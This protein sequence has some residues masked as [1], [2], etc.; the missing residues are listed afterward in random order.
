MQHARRARILRLMRIAIA[1][2]WF[3]PRQGG[4]ESQL[5]TLAERLAG[6]GHQVT[7]LTST[8]GATNGTNYAL[9]RIDGPHLPFADVAISPMLGATLRAAI[10]GQFDVVHAH[11]SVVSPVGYLAAFAAASQ[12]I[13]TVVTFH[14]V[15]RFK[16]VLLS[17]ANAVAQLGKLPIIWT[18]VSQLVAQQVRAGLGATDVDVL[19]NGIDLD[20]WREPDRADGG[21]HPVTF[22]SAMRLHRKKRP[23]ELVAAFARAADRAGKPARLVIAGVGPELAAVQRDIAASRSATV[24]VVGWQDKANLKA[25]YRQSDAFVLPSLREA[26]GIAALEARAAGLP[27]IASR[28]AGCREFLQHDHNA[29]LCDTDAEFAAAIERFVREPDLR[30]RLASGMD[31]L[32]HYDWDV[33][34]EKH[35]RVYALAMKASARVRVPGSVRA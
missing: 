11:V 17:A 6:R 12:G 32:D 21:T 25:L 23:R 29:L 4:I 33:V 9:R 18:A 22:V 7:V 35:E 24:D 3:L 1:T 2:D 30:R 13:A 26:F 8:R 5:A 31:A 27:V 28:S 10:R 34:L 16:Q 14:S 15:L 20:Y 19:P